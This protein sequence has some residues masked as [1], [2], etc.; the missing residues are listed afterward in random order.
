MN[1]RTSLR[2]RLLD[3]GRHYEERQRY[4]V[5]YYMWVP[6]PKKPRRRAARQNMRDS[7]T[8]VLL[9]FL[10]LVVLWMNF[11]PSSRYFGHETR[12]TNT[13]PQSP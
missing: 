11:G 3:I 1:R 6:A 9:A 2:R 7:Q 13:I 12:I 5:G 10:L 8:I 4:P